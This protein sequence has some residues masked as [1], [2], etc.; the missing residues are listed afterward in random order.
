MQTCQV[1]P[2][3]IVHRYYRVVQLRIEWRIVDH[4]YLSTPSF[5]VDLLGDAGVVDESISTGA[6]LCVPTAYLHH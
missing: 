3:Q 1:V 6:T 4:E 2:A 5:S